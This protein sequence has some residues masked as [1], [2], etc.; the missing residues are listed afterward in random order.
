MWLTGLKPRFYAKTTAEIKWRQQQRLLLG[1][2]TY[3]LDK[4][5]TNL[6]KCVWLGI[7]EDLDN[8]FEM[9]RYQAGLDLKIE[10][11]N[12]NHDDYQKPSIAER[13]KMKALMPMDVYLYE[14][15]KQLHEYRYKMFTEQQQLEQ[16][17]PQIQYKEISLKLP[18]VLDGCKGYSK[19][20]ECHLFDKYFS[21]STHFYR[22]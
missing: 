3:V 13:E 9:L 4:A 1:N 7:V 5:F 14:Y 19:L 2:W 6:H 16:W 18:E 11:M 21:S 8:S 22:K 10:R 17:Q 20:F 15:A 12:V